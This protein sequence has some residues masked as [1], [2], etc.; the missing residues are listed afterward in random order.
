MDETGRVRSKLKTEAKLL[1]VR[2]L[3]AEMDMSRQALY[4]MI[5]RS[6]GPKPIRFPGG[7]YVFAAVRLI[8]GWTT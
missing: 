2:T 7:C 3:A 6:K 5:F 4:A 8:D 1:S